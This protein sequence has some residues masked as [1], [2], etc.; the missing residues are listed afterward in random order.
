MRDGASQ[1]SG[2]VSDRVTVLGVD[3]GGTYLR[4]AAADDRREIHAE[5]SEEVGEMTASRLVD[6]IVELA[7]D[8]CD[9]SLD[10]ITVGLPAPVSWSGEVG[11]VV[12][13]PALSGMPVGPM[14]ERE[15]GLPV[16]VENDVNLAALGEQ[17]SGSAGGTE[18]MVF[19]GV[20]TG[21][22]MG[23][24]AGGRILHG[25]H[26][27]AGELGRLP[28]D[29]ERVGTGPGELGPLEEVAGGAGLARRWSAHIS[30]DADGREVYAAAAAGD[31]VAVGLLES[32]AAALAMGV[33]AV[34][35]L[36][37]PELVVFGGGIGSR[38]DVFRSVEQV[39]ASRPLPLPSLAQSI[40]G[41]RA[42]LLGA[43]EAA[44]DAT[45][46]IVER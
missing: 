2:F 18:D 42:S 17:R 23:I 3:L 6:R 44:L 30:R 15:L 7:E 4:A 19:I 20:G 45:K 40:L 38:P 5:V 10:A 11:H 16:V 27:G 13:L 43:V 41:D 1:G 34:H 31:P 46:G 32:Q 12:N 36:L 22:G 39:L 8:L 33:R 37:D 21:V 24:V 35:A 29:A 28:L 26:G 14:L 25:A 9:G